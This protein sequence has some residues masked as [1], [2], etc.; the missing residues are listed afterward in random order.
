MQET[1]RKPKWLK[2]KIPGGKGYTEL[3]E[4][5][6][7]YNLHTVCE[8]A[9]CP[10]L[11]ECWSAGVG[12]IMILGDTCTRACGFC[13]VKTGRPGHYDVEEAQ[14]AAESI[15]LMGLKYVTITSVNRDELPDQGSQVW[16][17]TITLTKQLVPNIKIEVLTPDFRGNTDLLDTVLD[18]R[19]DVYNHNFETIIRLQKSVR[20][21]ANWHDSRTM[22]LHAKSRNF[23]T[24]TGLMVGLGETK[25][26]VFA[27]IDQ[28]AEYKV[29]I[30]SIGQYLQPTK[31]HLTVDRYVTP[32]EFEEYS[33]YA[34]KA[35]IP[36]CESGPLVR[37]SYHAEDQSGELV[38]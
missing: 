5:M 20:K 9:K 34:K 22:L 25:E 4:R 38:Q 32:E 15:K 24:K 23:L 7:K 35:G 2:A 3:K 29:D 14:R 17:D 11:G 30:L 21:M 31:K 33:E 19:P 6:K 10:N 18:A 27:F 26:E 37:S 8:E 36:R 28:V 12:T 16:A 1:Q 13:N